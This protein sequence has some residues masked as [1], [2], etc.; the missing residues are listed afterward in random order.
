MKIAKLTGLFCV[1]TALLVFAAMYHPDDNKVI[2]TEGNT[3]VVS[4]LCN[5][6]RA[7]W[8]AESD[9]NESL[10]NKQKSKLEIDRT[11]K[12]GLTRSGYE[13]VRTTFVE[14]VTSK[15]CDYYWN[16]LAN[17]KDNSKTESDNV[18]A[19]YK[20][21]E[22]V[23]TNELLV[24]DARINKVEHCQQVYVE[25]CRLLNPRVTPKFDSNKGDFSTYDTQRNYIL[26]R[27]KN[28]RT[29]SLFSYIEHIKG[30]KDGLEDSRVL[31]RITPSKTEYYNDLQ[32]KI[33]VYF[34]AIE[35]PESA[36]IDNFIRVYN[37]LSNEVYPS[38]EV[39]S[40]YHKYVNMKNK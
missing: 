11:S 16:A 21:V 19:H 27:A 12:K 10:Y 38:S 6:I 40:L 8:D 36:D 37:K 13:V 5:E 18:R 34:S 7:A 24:G 1:V 29:D 23:K 15:V 30:F 17:N 3:P 33:V 14:K 35:S 20:Y 9:W 26:Q 39:A 4:E 28:C 31:S 22:D 25:A 32:D 2:Q